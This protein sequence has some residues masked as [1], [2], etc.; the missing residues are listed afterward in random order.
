MV[1]STDVELLSTRRSPSVQLEE[2]VKSTVHSANALVGT[3][4]MGT[5]TD[6]M[7]VVDSALKVSPPRIVFCT[8]LPLSMVRAKAP[9][10]SYP[11]YCSPTVYRV[12]FSRTTRYILVPLIG[13]M[14]VVMC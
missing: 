1:C 14:L 6:K 12:D 13:M 10:L 7:A 2:Y 11:V 3:C 8:I 9:W 5:E 4:K